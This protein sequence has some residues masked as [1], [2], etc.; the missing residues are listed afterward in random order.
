MEDNEAW[1]LEKALQ[2]NEV[3]I[4]LRNRKLSMIN[5]HSMMLMFSAIMAAKT[6]S[7]NLTT[8]DWKTTRDRYLQDQIMG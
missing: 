1:V 7:N 6:D 8:R 5:Y 3:R 4:E 2:G